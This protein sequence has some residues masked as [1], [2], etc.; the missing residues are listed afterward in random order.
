[1]EMNKRK[2]VVIG[3]SS[4]I[5]FAL[6]ELLMSEGT[7]VI[8]ASR[9]SHKLKHAV[10]RLYGKVTAQVVDMC[11]QSSLAEFFETVGS[12]TDLVVAA[13]EIA[14]GPVA[15]L[16]VEVA[17]QSF[18][19]KFW[20]PY[21]TVKAALPHLASDGSITLFS[22]GF[23]Q[24]PKPGAAVITAI[25]CAIEGLAKALALEIAP[26]RI[27]VVAPGIT[28][29]EHFDSFSP[30]E[31]A[32]FFADFCKDLPIARAAQPVEIA[33]SALFLMTNTYSTGAT[34]YVDG[35]YTA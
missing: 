6:A 27:N 19:N 26:I 20:G 3:G 33:R 14:F 8:I 12:F 2:V 28:D 5:G 7:E 9:S 30:T 11:D 22:G 23:S 24:R 13:S 31:K 34:V 15:E 4:G 10:D 16:P 17:K 35:G 1:M 18:E 25:N 21:Q 32:D 29:T